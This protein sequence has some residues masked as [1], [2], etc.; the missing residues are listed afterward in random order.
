MYFGRHDF[1]NIKGHCFNGLEL[2][3]A[4]HLHALLPKIKNGEYL[5]IDMSRRNYKRKMAEGILNFVAYEI[6]YKGT[7]FVL[8]CQVRRN[9]STVC[10]YPYSIKQKE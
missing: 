4:Q 8:K 3:V 6:D 2:E 9:G 5:P 10:E 1:K 7:T